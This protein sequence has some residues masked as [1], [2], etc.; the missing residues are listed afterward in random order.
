VGKVAV[1]RSH[2]AN[3]LPPSHV[4]SQ[5]RDVIISK[6]ANPSAAESMRYLGNA[7]WLSKN[8]DQQRY[9]PAVEYAAL[10]VPFLPLAVA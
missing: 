10:L 2:Y 8:G 6:V 7:V 9:L 3:L 5:G 4:S 1:D